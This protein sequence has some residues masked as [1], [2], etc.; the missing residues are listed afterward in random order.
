MLNSHMVDTDEIE[1]NIILIDGKVKVLLIVLLQAE[2]SHINT[3][4]Y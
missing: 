2:R 4:A 3:S 1:L